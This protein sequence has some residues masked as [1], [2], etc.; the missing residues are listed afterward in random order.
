MLEFHWNLE[1]QFC[2]K[3]MDHPCRQQI[4]I[5]S[6]IDCFR[7]GRGCI[8]CILFFLVRFNKA[9]RGLFWD[10]VFLSLRSEVRGR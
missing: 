10:F 4:L 8:D 9:A 3:R 6:I 5:C 7:D 1:E 2:S